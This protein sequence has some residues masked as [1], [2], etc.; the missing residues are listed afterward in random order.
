MPRDFAYSPHHHHY[1]HCPPPSSLVIL[2]SGAVDE[3]TARIQGLI[4]EMRYL[5]LY[6]YML[7]S[8]SLSIDDEFSILEKSNY[9]TGQAELNAQIS[10]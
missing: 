6:K 1:H 4:I 5:T 2:E 8:Q 3:G 9:E 10:I 7:S